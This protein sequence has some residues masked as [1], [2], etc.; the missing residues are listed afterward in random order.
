[1][2]LAAPVD[3]ETAIANG[4]DHLKGKKGKEGKKRNGCGGTFWPG[5][6]NL[7]EAAQAG[8]ATQAAREERQ[9]EWQ[10]QRFADRNS[11]AVFAIVKTGWSGKKLV[12]RTNRTRSALQRFKEM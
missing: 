5:E 7:S 6:R 1:M 8:Q 9:K 12:L 3:L 11:S 4:G 2:P 10:Q